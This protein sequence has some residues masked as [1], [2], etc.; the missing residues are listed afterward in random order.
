MQLSQYGQAAQEY[1]HKGYNC[2]Q[3]VVAPFAA[4][5]GLTEELA[6]RMACGFGG[7]VG[8]MREVCGAFCGITM[9]VSLRYADPANPQ[10]KSRIYAIVQ[11]LAEQYKAQ[12][13]RGSYLCRDL[14]AG[15]GA[16]GGAQAEERT[17]DYYKRRPCAEL[18]RMAAELAADY[19]EQHP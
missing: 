19:L 3:S 10:D 17:Q 16:S 9:I 8:R 18:V 12:S 13:G 5:L 2:C 1:F 6:L 15:T 14:L 11:Q 4:Q 7:G